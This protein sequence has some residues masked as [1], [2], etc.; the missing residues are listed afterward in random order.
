MNKFAQVF[1]LGHQISL[2]RGWGWG[3]PARG[4]GGM[5]RG[6]LYDEVQG[7]ICNGHMGSHPCGQT[8]TTENITFPQLNCQMIISKPRA[9]DTGIVF[10]NNMF[11]V[12]KI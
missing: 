12:C 7:I 1:S 10:M 9:Y 5:A 11:V 3:V 8:N 2:V 4:G 6:S